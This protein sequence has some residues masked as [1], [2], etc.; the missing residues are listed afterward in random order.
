VTVE[1]HWLEGHYDSLPAV[2]GDLV[3]RRVA[4]IATPGTTQG[5][6]RSQSCDY[7]TADRSLYRRSGARNQ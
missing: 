5:S 2:I 1:Y 3:R 7:Q 6:G 4:V